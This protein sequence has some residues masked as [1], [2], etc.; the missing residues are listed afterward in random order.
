M[1]TISGDRQPARRHVAPA[2]CAGWRCARTFV[3]GRG[4]PRSSRCG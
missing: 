3:A 4:A 1:T 2:V